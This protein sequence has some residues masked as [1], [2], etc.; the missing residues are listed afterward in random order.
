MTENIRYLNR[1]NRL[2]EDDMRDYIILHQLLEA[3]M[4]K[5]PREMDLDL[6]DECSAQINELAGEGPKHSSAA[7]Q[8]KI[9]E[10]MGVPFDRVSHGKKT[11]KTITAADTKNRHRTRKFFIILAASLV[12]L[13]SSLTVAAK[14]QGYD[15]AWEFIAQKISEIFDPNGSKTFKENNITLVVENERV[16]YNSV[17]S[18]LKDEQLDILYPT[19]LPEETSLKSVRKYIQND[20]KSK[21]VFTYNNESLSITMKNYYTYDFSITEGQEEINLDYCLFRITPLD[22]GNFQAS[23]QH[24]GYEYTI[25]HSNHAELL[26]IINS[27][28]GSVS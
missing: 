14:V 27:M 7:V 11:P 13:Y 4:S 25:V 12:L 1:I 22:N 28:K 21:F 17:G 23:C 16:I 20:G 26:K 10:I 15:N 18:L 2:S 24:N 5:P 19:Y 3:E 9:N 8:A 6:I